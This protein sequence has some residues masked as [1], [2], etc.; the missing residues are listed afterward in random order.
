VKGTTLLLGNDHNKMLCVLDL[1][2]NDGEPLP[3]IRGHVN[4]ESATP[5][6]YRL[7]SG[8]ANNN[9]NEIGSIVACGNI[10]AVASTRSHAAYL[11]SFREVEDHKDLDRRLG[12]ASLFSSEADPDKAVMG[13]KLAEG[14]LMV[15]ASPK[16]PSLKAS[17]DN[18]GPSA[19]AIRGR[20]LVCGYRN[21]GVSKFELPQ[22]WELTGIVKI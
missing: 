5:S 17:R 20:L 19:V 7:Q 6:S 13:R 9:R 11:F 3:R 10:M 22:E 21:G 1:E 12:P 18:D 16:L 8:G 4:L 15:F 14:K 2:D